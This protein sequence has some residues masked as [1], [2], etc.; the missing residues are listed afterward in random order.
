M[1]LANKFN[2]KTAVEEIKEDLVTDTPP[3]VE[4]PNQTTEVA[5]E[6]DTVDTLEA[7]TPIPL[8]EDLEQVPDHTEELEYMNSEVEKGFEAI[9]QLDKIAKALEAQEAKGV[10][11]ESYNDFALIAINN[12][13]T[14]LGM[15]SEAGD[16]TSEK[17]ESLSKKVIEAIK[18]IWEKLISFVNSIIS[19]ITNYFDRSRKLYDKFSTYI[20]EE[21]IDTK[22]Y[23]INPRYYRDHET[24]T[25]ELVF[26]NEYL[27]NFDHNLNIFEKY[28]E[29]LE[30]IYHS[31]I[32]EN[33]IKHSKTLTELRLAESG[34]IFT[35]RG[36]TKKHTDHITVKISPDHHFIKL[37]DTGTVHYH[38][39]IP[40]KE[41][42]QQRI[43]PYKGDDKHFNLYKSY[44]DY[45]SAIEKGHTRLEIRIKNLID[46][47]LA[48]N[49]KSIEKYDIDTQNSLKD[50]LSYLSRFNVYFFQYCTGLLE[51]P[52]WYIGS[53]MV[54]RNK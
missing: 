41:I 29:H 10:S 7:S 15:E 50:L 37:E 9:A 40:Y 39:V 31:V 45:W 32:A 13:R 43:M 8:E 2:L 53:T 3:V 52:N 28:F 20:K 16:V 1:S 48:K 24:V 51:G 36:E 18:K 11:L 54:K 5:N 34:C 33:D 19:K 21:I 42:K 46:N 38:R 49:I 26:E 22:V 35:L 14:S 23:T 25:A 12:V 6:G 47:K 4:E 30:H 44:V 27:K 17:T